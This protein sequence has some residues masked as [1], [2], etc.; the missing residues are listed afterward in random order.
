[1]PHGGPHEETLASVEQQIDL[2]EEDLEEEG[3]SKDA[4]KELKNKI[5]ALKTKIKELKKQKKGFIPKTSWLGRF[6][7]GYDAPARAP[8]RF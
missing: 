2:L 5:K 3:L 7:G 1:M 8:L 6:T 4:R